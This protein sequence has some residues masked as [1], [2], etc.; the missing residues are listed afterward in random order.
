MRRWFG[1]LICLAAL[2]AACGGR[3]GSPTSPSTSNSSSANAATISGTVQGG[4]ASALTAAST[5]AALS[6]VMV[7]VVG[8]SITSGVDAAGRF[9]LANVPPGNVQL[10]ISGGGV[11]ATVSLNPVQAAQTVDVVVTVSGN[12]ANVDSD[13][14]SGAGEAELEGRVESLPPTMPALTFK[15]A[16][17]TVTTDGSTQF[18]DGGVTRAFSDLRIGMRVHVKGRMSGDMFIATSVRL[19]NTNT[20]IKVEVNG[21][22]DT[23]TGAASAFQFKI[24][25]R[26]IRGDSTTEFF[27]DGNSPDSF[28]DLKDGVR[29]EVKGE[30]RDD[31]I[32][33]TRIHI[34]DNDDDDDDDEDSSASIHGTLKSISG[35]KPNLVLTVDS[36]TVRTSSTTEVKRKGDVQTLDALKTGQKLH[37]VGTRQG[38]GSLDARKIE[39]NDDEEGGE[40]ELE[41]SL[42][43]LTGTCPAISFSVNGFR[44]VASASTE[45]KDVSCSALESGDKV[46][47][48]GTRQANG[49]VNATRIERK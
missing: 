30:Q 38:D 1:F 26:V 33:A 47:V 41:G 45:F 48:K 2:S 11:D 6:G 7:T 27:G 13:V 10:R 20:A 16:G 34:N 36:T 17:R 37:V 18:S 40:F 4:G 8:T 24:G 28:A 31:F 39:I 42:G 22:V 19:Q 5:G 15:A 29:V 46:E 35:S 25:S 32:F 12:S 44:I 21:V 3:S 49:S 43:G 23:V 9:M 14:R